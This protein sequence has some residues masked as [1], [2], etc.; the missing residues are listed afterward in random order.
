MAASAALSMMIPGQFPFRPEFALG[1]V[2]FSP[3]DGEALRE[4]EAIAIENNAK[5][6]KVTRILEIYVYYWEPSIDETLW[7]E[8]GRIGDLETRKRIH[9]SAEPE[10]HERVRMLENTGF[11]Q[12]ACPNFYSYIQYTPDD[13]FF[14]DSSSPTPSNPPNQWDKHII[15]CPQA[16]DIQKG[17]PNILIAIL[18]SG[19]DV[20]HPDLADNIWVNPGEDIDDLGT[21]ALVYDYD[22]IDGLDNDGNGYI[23][24]LFGYDFV[25][26]ITGDEATTPPDQEDWNPDVHYMGDDGW[27]EPDPSA[28]NGVGS[29]MGTDVGVAHG[30]HCAG[31]AAAVMDNATMFAGV[32][33]GGC[34]IVPVRVANPE[35]QASVTAIAAGIEYAAIIGADVISMSLG[36]FGSGDPV[37]AA[38]I[39][40]AFSAGATLVAA[41]GNMAPLVTAVSYPASDPDVIAVGS[42]NAAGGKSSYSQYGSN[43]DV[44]A[45][46][47]E[48]S[49]MGGTTETIWSTWVV[50]VNESNEDPSLSPADHVYMSAE[51]TS[52]ACPQAAGVCGLILSQNPS[53]TNV[54][55]RDVL[56][57]SAS[58]LGPSGFDNETGYGMVNAY[59]AV[60]ASNIYEKANRPEGMSIQA[61]P[62]P[63][64]AACRISAPAEVEIFDVSG[65]LIRKLTPNSDS[66]VI[67]DGSDENGKSLPS[68]VYLARTT[69]PQGYETKSITLLK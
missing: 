39:D 4:I 41:S 44:V 31:V 62:N 47:G 7:D 66:H 53:L 3:A 55:V 6:H 61:F 68:G 32:A 38:A 65:R 58:D 34:K 16:W 64:N 1:Q 37:Q 30:T 2:V 28:G 26:G 11:V 52:M 56:R 59:S 12:W 5:V 20:D 8:A 43:L 10:V 29:W 51:G 60:L 33:G 46:G 14:I 18:D 25:G 42:C 35:G 24:D 13:P 9:L 21:L 15:Q 27:G 19:V 17:D 36:G 23:D 48:S 40:L 67:W 63:F 45:P 50:S 49:W 22:Y 69:T 57:S 54:Q